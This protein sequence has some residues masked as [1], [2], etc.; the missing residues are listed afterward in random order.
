M[1]GLKLIDLQ[2]QCKN[3]GAFLSFNILCHKIV[4]HIVLT[5]LSRFCFCVDFGVGKQFFYLVSA[6]EVSTF[7]N[8]IFIAYVSRNVNIITSSLLTS[9][10]QFFR[11]N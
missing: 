2:K 8:V 4:N 5:A 3:V 7:Q 6:L 9:Y 1:I 10:V 11:K